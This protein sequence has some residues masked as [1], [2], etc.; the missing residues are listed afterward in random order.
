MMTEDSGRC[1]VMKTENSARFSGRVRHA[2]KLRGMQKRE[3]TTIH[4]FSGGVTCSMRRGVN[5]PSL[6]KISGI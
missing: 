1:G 2:Q 3:N 4:S 6:G 5:L